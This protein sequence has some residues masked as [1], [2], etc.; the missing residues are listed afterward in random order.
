MSDN[1]IHISEQVGVLISTTYPK[2]KQSDLVF[3]KGLP[4]FI[5]SFRNSAVT[6]PG[7]YDTGK[8][9][10]YYKNNSFSSLQDISILIHELFHAQ[11]YVDTHKNGFGFLRNFMVYYLGA[12]FTKGFKYF[13]HPMEIPAFTHQKKFDQAIESY[14]REKSIDF[15]AFLKEQH[16]EKCVLGAPDLICLTS[17][18]G[19]GGQKIAF[20]V[21]IPVA[22]ASGTLLY[23]VDAVVWVWKKISLR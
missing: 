14:L 6:L 13:E 21:G 16:I 11:Q 3:H 5:P 18:F 2:L 7:K 10:I 1:N 12:W 4:W 17:H 20:V 8:I 19:F 9:H 15:D 23:V 22:L